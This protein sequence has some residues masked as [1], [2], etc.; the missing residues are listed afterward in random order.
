[1][2]GRIILVMGT[3]GSG[4]SRFSSL[5]AEHLGVRFIEADEYHSPGN[6]GKMREGMPLTDEEREPWLKAL[7]IVLASGEHAD[8]AVLA[9]SALKEEYRRL[10]FSQ[11]EERAQVIYLKGS[12]ETILRQIQERSDHFFSAPLLS[13][14]F[15]TLEEPRDA[16]VVEL[17]SR[18]DFRAEINRLF[19]SDGGSVR[20][21]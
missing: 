13:S 7:S 10:L 8:G 5:L 1:M 6:I 15:E 3:A 17:D 4:K 18:P 12:Y 19:P 14:Q 21:P 20:V 2:N 11:L 9:C 16:L